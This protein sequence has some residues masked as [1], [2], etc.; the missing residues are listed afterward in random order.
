MVVTPVFGVPHAYDFTPNLLS[1]TT[2]YR[3]VLVCLHGWLLSRAY[4][5][6]LMQQLAP[7][8][9]C[10]AYDLRGFGD[11]TDQL[12]SRHAHSDTA[13]YSLTAYAQDLNALLE[14]L[15]LD[16]VWLMGHS[17]GGSIA[18]WAAH[19]F[20]ERVQGVICVNAGGGIYIH[21][22]F[23]KFRNA[24]Q[25]M[26][27]WRP[28]WLQHLPL[29][30]WVFANIMVRQPLSYRWGQQRLIDFLRA[31]P[32]AATQSLLAS[33]T[34]DEVH[35]LP[36]IV[37]KLSQ[38]VY[39]ITGEQDTVMEP[40]YVQHLASFHRFF[41]QGKQAVVAF[42]QC[43]HFAMLE[44]PSALEAQVRHWVLGSC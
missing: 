44:Q 1:T 30:P 37:S 18:L 25:Q 4:W 43:G 41:Y 6:P 5:Q 8:I 35:Q 34:E 20:P 24:G 17:L 36:N 13:P 7:D 12:L 28:Q 33:T 14:N 10:L 27:G 15:E 40:R 38:P 31:D 2:S 22:A 39:F 29:L 11:S 21:N 3:S 26:V 16:N 23:E 19:L 32:E 42:E 9:A